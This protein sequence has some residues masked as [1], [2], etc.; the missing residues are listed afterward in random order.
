MDASRLRLRLQDYLNR[1]WEGQY[2]LQTGQDEITFIAFRSLARAEEDEDP[3]CP[4]GAELDIAVHVAYN[5]GQTVVAV[6]S[7]YWMVNKTDR[8]LQYKAD[9]IHRKHPRDYDRPLLFS[10]KP[11]NFLQNNKVGGARL[12][13][14]PRGL[15]R[16][17][18]WS[19]GKG[20]W[21]V[22]WIER[23]SVLQVRL[24]VSDSELSDEF[25]LDTVGSHGD[26]KCKGRIK[27]YLVSARNCTPADTW[28]FHTWS[29]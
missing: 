6:H 18:L 12:A 19:L 27:D 14:S 21:L 9:D 1:D 5:P 26:V 10:F 4:E 15:A 8:L 23:V 3:A 7:P 20:M 13:G 2:S 28:W 24:M 17:W 29:A 25:S 16:D 22:G 11:R